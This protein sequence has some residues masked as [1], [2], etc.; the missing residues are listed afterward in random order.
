MKGYAI[1][2]KTAGM[3]FDIKGNFLKEFCNLLPADDPFLTFYPKKEKDIYKE[4][5]WRVPTQQLIL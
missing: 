1:K 4:E 3:G 5:K 2:D